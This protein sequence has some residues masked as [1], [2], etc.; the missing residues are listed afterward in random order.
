MVRGPLPRVA[1]LGP[2]RI[3][4]PELVKL[5]VG[6]IAHPVEIGCGEGCRLGRWRRRSRTAVSCRRMV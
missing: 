6:H 1:V 3:A 2:K 4:E 5:Q